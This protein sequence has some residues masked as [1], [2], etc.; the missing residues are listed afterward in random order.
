MKLNDKT[1]AS[2]RLAKVFRE[3]TD[4]VN[5]I[6]FSHD[7]ETMISS[8]SDDSIVLYCCMEG[9][10]KRTLYSKKYGCDLLQY[11]HA[12]NAIIYSSNKIDDQIRYLSLYD[13]KFLRYFP[14]HTKRVV[15]LRMSPIDDT[16]ISASL[17]KTI[18]LWDL[19]YVWNVCNLI[20]DNVYC[21]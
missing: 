18:R 21:T 9:K 11:T 4:C 16:F 14:G 6:D 20:S 8:S 2:M 7:G 15:S 1:M 13:N 12:P 10:P 19:R 5:C 3:N 17:D